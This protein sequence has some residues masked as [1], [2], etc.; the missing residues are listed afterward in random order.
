M[1]ASAPAATFTATLDRDTM[2]LGESV[3]LSLTFG[4]ATPGNVVGLPTIPN[5]EV[6]PAGTSSQMSFNFGSQSSSSI[7]YNYTVTARQPGDYTIPAMT[8]EVGGQKLS[9]QAL[10]L[11]VLKPG[12]PPPEAINS[13]AQIAFAKLIL[14]KTNIY[15]GESFIAQVQF[16]LNARAV[17]RYGQPQPTAFPADG[18][19]VGN[20]AA[21]QPNRIQFGDGVY[22]VI[23][24]YVVLKAV[25]AGPLTIGPIA[26]N[27]LVE[28]PSGRRR[29]PFFD[30]F[31]DLFGE[32]KQLAVAAQ[33]VPVQVLPLPRENAPAD[34]NGAVG[35][36]T[37][38]CTAGPTNIT[39][40]DPITVKVQITGHGSLD[41]LTLPEQAVWH[42]FKTFPPTTKVE[43][44][45]SLG[46]QGTK[47]F[48]Q[49]FIPE[50]ADVKA[51]PPITFSFFDPDHQTYRTLSQPPIPLVVR[52]GGAAPAPTIAASARSSQENSPP[53]QDIVP[54]K[55][56]LGTVAQ[57]GPPLAQQTWFLALQ[58]VPVLGFVTAVAWRRRTDSLANNPRLRRRRQVAQTI[59]DGLAELRQ[60]VAVNDS[61]K[62]FATLS[63][64]LQEQLGE[65]LDLPATAITEAVIEEHLRPGGVPETTL[66]PL[67]E[68][69]QT[70][71]LAR[72]APVKTSQELAALIPKLETVLR[73][74]QEAKV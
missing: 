16:Y 10:T 22:T 73:Q 33:A 61:E 35:S 2:T 32:R 74:L 67:Q 63:H 54:N 20:S 34:F 68:L 4:G 62:F 31:G 36:Y 50:N 70:C 1:V 26:A 39:A 41:S 27:V 24:L 21:G 46:L 11:R 37:L 19:N 7:S 23:P 44:T 14:P 64:L 8:V 43:T 28:L 69:F 66:A 9:S 58:S 47:T 48:E 72:Y 42:D 40:G 3:T 38:A 13:G 18:F 59:R 55:Q 49:I 56:H 71:N 57:I 25:K 29:D 65:C 5:L 17:Q 30:P 15:V 52:P 6:S 51:L 45:D 60:A 12:A 53:T